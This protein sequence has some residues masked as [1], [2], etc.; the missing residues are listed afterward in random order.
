MGIARCRNR[1]RKLSSPLHA[2]K[3]A[4]LQICGIARRCSGT[5]GAGAVADKTSPRLS[6]DP[7]C[8][9]AMDAP[10]SPPPPPTPVARKAHTAGAAGRRQNQQLARH[11]APIDSPLTWQWK[12]AQKR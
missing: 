8:D 3:F 2:S 7:T 9:G 11:G 1:V 5:A 10:E 12:Q 6:S 4:R